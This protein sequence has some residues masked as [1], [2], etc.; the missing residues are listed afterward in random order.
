MAELNQFETILA[1]NEAETQSKTEEVSRVIVSEEKSG[2]S[3]GKVALLGL[4]VVLILGAMAGFVYWRD[5]TWRWEKIPMREA[6]AR[7]TAEWPVEKLAGRLAE[8]GKVRDEKAFLQAARDAKL[9]IVR[10]GGYLLPKEAGPRDL[11]ALFAGGPQL[12]K[13]TFPEGWTAGQMARRLADQDFSEAATF[14]RLSYGTTLV[15]PWEGKLF[16]DTYYLAP[17][18]TGKQLI[19]RLNERF[20]EVAKDLPHPFPKIKGQELTLSQLVTLASL[21]E[22]ETD[23]PDERP[24]IAGVLLNR[25]NIN[26][27]LQCDATVQYARRRAEAMGQSKTGDGHKARLLFSDLKIDSPYNTYRVGGLPPGP[28]CNPGEAAL[29]A[30][31]RPEKS[32]YFF[33]VM[34]PKLG[35]H[36][37]AKT[38][39]EHQKNIALAKLER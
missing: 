17:K 35:R 33:Y 38:F 3:W 27:R 13:I 31:A 6:M 37:F 10:P 9:Q 34:S 20:N 30:A 18:A 29:K 1:E 14:N 11:A 36:R 5:F 23:V 2:I 21:V 8:S 26:M 19:A 7:V 39:A 15:S 4:V 25:L 12:L 16:P 24:L 32:P 22:R 28:I